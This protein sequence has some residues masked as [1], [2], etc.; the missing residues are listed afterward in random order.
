VVFIIGVLLGHVLAKLFLMFGFSP[1]V[2]VVALF[3]CVGLVIWFFFGGFFVG[4]FSTQ[5]TTHFWVIRF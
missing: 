5:L 2:P 3:F 4:F 1:C